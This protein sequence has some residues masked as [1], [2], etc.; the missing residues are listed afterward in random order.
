[1]LHILFLHYLLLHYLLLHSLMFYYVNVAPQW[2]LFM[3]DILYSGHLS[4]TDTFLRN[5][6]NDSQT[7]ITQPPCSAHF[8]ADTYL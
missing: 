8:I 5:R 1:M 4:T 2:N 7:L 3:A 6:W